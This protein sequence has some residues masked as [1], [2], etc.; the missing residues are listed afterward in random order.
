MQFP[1]PGARTQ[2]EQHGVQGGALASLHVDVTEM[3]DVISQ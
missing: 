3:H 2:L 1:L